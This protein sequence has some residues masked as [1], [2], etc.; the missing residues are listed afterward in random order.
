MVA[1]SAALCAVGL[2]TVTNASGSATAAGAAPSCATSGLV[3]WLDTQGDSAAGSVSFKLEFTNQSGRRCT[4]HGYPGV[5]AVDLRGR[6]LG[7][8]ASRTS[9]PL[10]V[11]SLASGATAS[12]GLRIVVAGNFPSA[13]CHRVAAAGV[14]VFPPNQTVSKVVPFPFEACAKS[15]PVYLNVK[16]VAK[17]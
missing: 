15:G 13:A 1:A 4:L 7:H 8:A 14:R 2:A 5:S 10:R 17:T 3:V 16:A 11:V 9:S 12:A 6:Q